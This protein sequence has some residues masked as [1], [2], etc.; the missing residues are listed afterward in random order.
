MRV[1]APSIEAVN[2]IP[3]TSPRIVADA[4][5]PPTRPES[6]ERTLSVST[7]T[8]RRPLKSASTRPQ[9]FVSRSTRTSST[10]SVVAPTPPLAPMT[11]AMVPFIGLVPAGCDEFVAVDHRNGR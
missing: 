1:N 5:L 7:A 10:H 6:K 2:S 9:A 11:I 4:R 8:E 3:A